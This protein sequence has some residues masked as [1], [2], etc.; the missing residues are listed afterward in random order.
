MYECLDSC[1]SMCNCHRKRKI[2][3]CVN[4]SL[5][6]V[7]RSLLCV[8]RS[9]FF[10]LS[11]FSDILLVYMH[12]YAV[13][14]VSRIDQIIGLFCK[15]ALQ[16]RLYSAKETDIILVSMHRCNARLPSFLLFLSRFCYFS[17]FSPI[18]LSF[19]LISLSYLLCLFR[20]SYF[21]L[22]SPT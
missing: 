9:D 19:F 14:L 6:C 4:R 21:S 10:A 13:A 20:F 16:K 8:N 15:R 1:L 12:R 7:N 17:L 2:F 22:I 11:Y 3:L 5:L 18:S